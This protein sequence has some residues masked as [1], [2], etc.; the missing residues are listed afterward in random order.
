M[1][2]WNYEYWKCFRKDSGP[3]RELAFNILWYL[4][5]SFSVF[6]E[7]NYGAEQCYGEPRK[8]VVLR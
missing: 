2:V 5:K 1:S 8:S 6:L 4:L 3:I 7:L